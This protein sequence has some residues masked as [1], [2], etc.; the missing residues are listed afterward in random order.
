LTCRTRDV[1][2]HEAEVAVVAE[3][4]ADEEKLKEKF[5]RIVSQDPAVRRRHMR[6]LLR[7]VNISR[8]SSE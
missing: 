5:S 4:Q 2:E 6:A 8:E 1:R 7:A 3:N